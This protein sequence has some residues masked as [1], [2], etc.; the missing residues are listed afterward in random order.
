MTMGGQEGTGSENRANG[1]LSFIK[2]LAEAGEGGSQGG[3]SG[4]P[5]S[6]SSNTWL[7]GERAIESEGS[8]RQEWAEPEGCGAQARNRDSWSLLSLG[9]QV[10]YLGM[11]KLLVGRFT[12]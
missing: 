10:L 1:S 2:G 5:G 3:Q 4:E 12:F 7:L 6:S 8:R 11:C 9:P